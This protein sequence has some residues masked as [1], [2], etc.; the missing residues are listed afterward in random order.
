[1]GKRVDKRD[2]E[3]DARDMETTQ[4]TRDDVVLA[5]A[6]EGINPQSVYGRHALASAKADLAFYDKPARHHT[7]EHARINLRN[8]L[9]WAKSGLARESA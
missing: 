5:V 7:V 9:Q 4:L 8:A 1:L 2:D 3:E 6:L